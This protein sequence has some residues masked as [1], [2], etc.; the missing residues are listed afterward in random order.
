[1]LPGS[2]FTSSL[3]RIEQAAADADGAAQRGVVLRQFLAAQRAGRINAGAGF[4]DDHIGNAV[5]FQ[6]VGQKIGQQFFRFAA[7]GA[8]AQGDAPGDCVA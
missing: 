7:G 6:F 5:V 1:M 2:I 8:V 3:E 4:V